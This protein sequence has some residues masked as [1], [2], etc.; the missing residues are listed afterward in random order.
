MPS[1]ETTFGIFF[2]VVC[3]FVIFAHEFYG[4]FPLPPSL[5]GEIEFYPPSK[6]GGNGNKIT[7]WKQDNS[8]ETR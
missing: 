7:Q 6:D 1:V 2:W 5:D 3:E 4:L 8:M